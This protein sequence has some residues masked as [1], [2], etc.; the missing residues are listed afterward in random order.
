MNYQKFKL[1]LSA[2]AGIG[3][4]KYNKEWTRDEMTD[5]FVTFDAGLDLYGAFKFTEHFGAFLA[6]KGMYSI[7]KGKR[8]YESHGSPY[9]SSER[10]WKLN[11]FMITPGAGLVIC[12]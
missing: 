9:P 10:K 8:E 6:C 1:V 11:G 4:Q 3:F 5:K 12:F 2:L 7:G